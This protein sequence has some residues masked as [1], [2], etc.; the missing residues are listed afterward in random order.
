MQDT[1]WGYLLGVQ[2]LCIHFMSAFVDQ[3][4]QVTLLPPSTFYYFPGDES[5]CWRKLQASEAS[6]LA[7]EFK[8]YDA[9][10]FRVSQ[11]LVRN[12]DFLQVCVAFSILFRCL[13]CYR[14]PLHMQSLWEGH[15]TQVNARHRVSV[16]VSFL[17][18]VSY[19]RFLHLK[20]TVWSLKVTNHWQCLI[21][22]C[23]KGKMEVGSMCS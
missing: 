19:A 14:K 21:S 2:V 13:W 3:I 6:A 22:R 18:D 15:S 9:L 11:L 7:T 12:H 20:S 5:Q 1:S 17:Q 8:V 4:N 16:H 23:E 10:N